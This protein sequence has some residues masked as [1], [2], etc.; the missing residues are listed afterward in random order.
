MSKKKINIGL[1]IGV[2]SV[3]WSIIDDENNLINYGSRLFPDAA[4][5][6]TGRPKNEDRRSKRSARRRLSRIKNRK[7]DLLNLFISNNLIVDDEEFANILENGIEEDENG[8]VPIV[9][10]KAKGLK[11][12]LSKEEMLLSLYHYIHH[13]GYFYI[14]EKD[15]EKNNKLDNELAQSQKNPSEI[16]L[17]FFEKN[18]Y[19][20]GMDENQNFPNWKWKKEIEIFL[21]KQNLSNEFK[22]KYLDLFCRVRDFATGPGSKKVRLLMVFIE[23]KL[24][25]QLGKIYEIKQLEDVLFI[26]KKI[27]VEKILQLL[28][29]LIF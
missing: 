29:F 20:K 26:L 18:G 25:Y 1:D 2:A 17:E 19:Y 3:G 27:E 13:R 28:K 4:D 7:R 24:V 12:K 21:E 8:S 9:K 11:E 5:E 22:E 16:Q 10:I 6:E 15:L 23:I 14:T